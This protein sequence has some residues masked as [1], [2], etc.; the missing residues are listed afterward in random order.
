MTGTPAPP[1]GKLPTLLD[2]TTERTVLDA[3]RALLPSARAWDLATGFFEIGAF[4]LLDGLW[5]P[6]EKIRLVMGD[7]TTRRTRRERG[8]E[9]QLLRPPMGDTPDPSGHSGAG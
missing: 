8:R 6:V 1:D 3:L 7:E 9:H 4:P 5:Q 2:N